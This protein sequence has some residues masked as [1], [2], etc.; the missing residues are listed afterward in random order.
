MKEVKKIITELYKSANTYALYAEFAEGSKKEYK[1]WKE[2]EL[3]VRSAIT[4][5]KEQFQIV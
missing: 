5:L 1:A 2:K 4:V 3:N